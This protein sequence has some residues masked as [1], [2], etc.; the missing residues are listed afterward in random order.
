MKTI[1][2][3]GARKYYLGGKA[4][5]WK[6][7]SV[8]HFKAQCKWFGDYLCITALVLGIDN[9]E[10]GVIWDTVTMQWHVD[11]FREWRKALK[12]IKQNLL[13]PYYVDDDLLGTGRE[14]GEDE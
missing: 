4:V 2:N 6:K 9:V 5:C 14:G 7:K 1:F 3:I 10:S 12:S 11:E 8:M 13:S